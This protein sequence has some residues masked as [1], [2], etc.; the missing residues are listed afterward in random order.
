[1]SEMHDGLGSQLIATL[2]LI[3]DGETARAQA[4]DSIRECLDGLRLAI[5]S[6]EPTDDDLLTVLGGLRYRL[7]ARLKKRGI[8][9]LWQV[10]DIPKLNS[11]TPQNVLH[12]LRILQETF[13]NIVKHAGART[14]T[15]KT[16][17]TQEQIF[18]EVADD[19]CG[20]VRNNE[21]GRGLCNMRKRAQALG[22]K[23]ELLPSSS[24]T[25]V[26]LYLSRA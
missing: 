18:I 12:I 26:G 22:A 7:E 20:F 4:A 16:G 5:H 19:G 17:C 25:T 9:L 10:R 8:A 6:L 1:M 24:G 3:E 13:T 23:L 14:I 15:V 21:G 11:L 2:E